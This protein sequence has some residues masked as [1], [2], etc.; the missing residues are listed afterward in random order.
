MVKF[1]QM[2]GVGPV[3]YY[4]TQGYKRNF[5]HSDLKSTKFMVKLGKLGEISLHFCSGHVTNVT[6]NRKI[7][8]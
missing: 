5:T 4:N 8:S 6:K 2:P 3:K 7:D 1:H